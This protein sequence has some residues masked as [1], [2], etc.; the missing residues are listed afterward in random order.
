MN[1]VVTAGPTR[2]HLDPVRFLSNRSTGKM[3]YAIADEA[4]RR[5]HAVHLISGP[6]AIPVPAGLVCCTQITSAQEMLD[7]VMETISESDVLIMCAA[8][9]DWRPCA[10]SSHK[11]KKDAMDP[12]LRLEP[13][14]DILGAVKLVRRPDQLIIGFAAETDDVLGHAREKVVRKNLDLIVANDVSRADAGFAVD[15]NIVSFV[16]KTGSVMDFPLLSKRLVGE[17]L[18]DWV[19]A[20]APETR[21]RANLIL[22]AQQSRKL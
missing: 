12:V 19:E 11:L 13:T 1:I 17:K 2:E 10:V 5:G 9:A 4:Q 15:T 7:A 22:T 6:V 14:K 16:E 20:H 21:T 3:G 18:M 8:V